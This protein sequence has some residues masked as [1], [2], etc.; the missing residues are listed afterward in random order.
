MRISELR[1]KLDQ[2]EAAFGDLSIVCPGE[3]YGEFV[4]A[5]YS[6]E[7]KEKTATYGF[8]LSDEDDIEYLDNPEKVLV[9]A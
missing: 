6:I 1:V 5:G 9:I 4:Y 2:F 8:E 7:Y 3:H